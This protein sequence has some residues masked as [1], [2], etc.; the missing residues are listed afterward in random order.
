ML[1]ILSIV[2]CSWANNNVSKKV[3]FVDNLVKRKVEVII[4]NPI[5]YQAVSNAVNY[6]NQ[7]GVEV[8]ALDR[9]VDLGKI[10]SHI[11]SNNVVGGKMAAEYMIHC[12][13]NNVNILDLQGGGC[14]FNFQRASSRSEY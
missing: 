5:N 13:S 9:T 14:F 6:A 2:G 4:I 12:L 11:E 8:I 3:S 1:L 10:L 7:Y